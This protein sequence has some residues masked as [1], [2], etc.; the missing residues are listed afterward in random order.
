M[1]CAGTTNA[2][3]DEHYHYSTAGSRD[4]GLSSTG[5]PQ[6]TAAA[7]RSRFCLSCGSSQNEVRPTTLMRTTRCG[8]S[9][10]E[11]LVVSARSLSSRWNE[12]ILRWQC[13]VRWRS[14]SQQ[15]SMHHRASPFLISQVRTHSLSQPRTRNISY[16]QFD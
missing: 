7:T 14:G 10:K 16:R 3:D 5:D 12:L 6:S 8:C 1:D 15:L 11:K 4:Q 9:P 2:H 13:A